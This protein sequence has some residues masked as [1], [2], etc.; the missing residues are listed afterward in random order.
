MK[1]KVQRRGSSKMGLVWN[2]STRSFGVEDGI[3]GLR[4]REEPPTKLALIWMAFRR[5]IRIE[6]EL[7][8]DLTTS[9]PSRTGQ[10]HVVGVTSV[11]LKSHGSWL[12]VFLYEGIGTK[13]WTILTIKKW[14]SAFSWKCHFCSSGR[15]AVIFV[16]MAYPDDPVINVGYGYSKAKNDTHTDPIIQ[17][18]K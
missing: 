7:E 3:N 8:R 10:F 13:S 12:P 15:V 17:A 4:S 11:D 1:T 18:P 6:T 2:P 5:N 9:W 16:A 14:T